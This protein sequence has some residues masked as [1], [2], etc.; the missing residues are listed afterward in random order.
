MVPNCLL[1]LGMSLK[2]CGARQFEH[3]DV[4]HTMIWGPSVL[5]IGICMIPSVYGSYAAVYTTVNILLAILAAATA[6]EFWRVRG[7]YHAQSRY[8]II[9]AYAILSVSFAGRIAQ[10][11][12]GG[13]QM[14]RHLPDDALLMVHLSVALVHLVASG[15]FALSLTYERDAARLLWLANHDP[16][17]GLLNR[18]AFE[19]RVRALA[20]ESEW[21]NAAILLIDMDHFKQINDRHGHAA[22]DEALKVCGNILTGMFSDECVVAR[23]GGDEFAAVLPACSPEQARTIA[24]RISRAVGQTAVISHGVRVPISVSVGVCHASEHYHEFAA[25]MMG[26]DAALYT[27][28]AN[29]RGRA[30]V[31]AA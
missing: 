1:V 17:T 15:A 26:A 19:E 4:H 27:A 2:W 30:E 20:K 13:D 31:A 5:F 7:A 22:G 14:G 18:G 23:W 16:L 29:G 8:A 25:L 24:E 21:R 9:V 28:K 11:I 6:M 12:L 3:K 10:G